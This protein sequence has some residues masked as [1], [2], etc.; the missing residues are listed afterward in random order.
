LVPLLSKRIGV[1]ALRGAQPRN[2]QA[3]LIPMSTK[4]DQRAGALDLSYFKI[5]YGANNRWERTRI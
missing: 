2:A 4:A 3:Y 1:A 5:V